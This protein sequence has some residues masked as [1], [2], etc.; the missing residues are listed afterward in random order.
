MP[1][2]RWLA[3][4]FLYLE[5]TVNHIN[6]PQQTKMHAQLKDAQVFVSFPRFSQLLQYY[7]SG[8]KCQGRQSDWKETAILANYCWKLAFTD[9]TKH[10]KDFPGVSVV[11]KPPVNAG[12]TSSIPGPVRSHMPRATKP[13]H[14]NHWSPHTLEPVL[15]NKR[16]HHNEKPVHS[17][18][19]E[20]SPHSNKDPAQPKWIRF[21]K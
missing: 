21:K 13:V 11:K 12:N 7:S 15:C 5:V 6:I 4:N 1:M 8:G 17:P 2:L 14:Y 3:I 19:L 9:A 16:S 18:Q 10:T 20:K